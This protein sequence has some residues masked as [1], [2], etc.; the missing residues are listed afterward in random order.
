M[1][2][3]VFLQSGRGGGSKR[4]HKKGMG[5][6]YLTSIAKNY[7]LCNCLLKQPN[8][9]GLLE[10]TIDGQLNDAAQ[11]FDPRFHGIEPLR[12]NIVRIF[13]MLVQIRGIQKRLKCKI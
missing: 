7:S 6:P 9:R 1:V 3:Y 11:H 12:L 13:E 10:S 5:W 8:G 4:F 2:C